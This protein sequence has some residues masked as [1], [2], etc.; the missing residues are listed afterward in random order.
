MP[1]SRQVR[2]TRTAISPRFATNTLVIG[3]GT[4]SYPKRVSERVSEPPGESTRASKRVDGTTRF[5]EVQWFAEID[6][7]NRYLIEQA[8]AGAP[9]GLVAVADLQHSG[10]GRLGRVWTAPSGA[11][12][13]VSVLVRPRLPRDHW[14]WLT[15]A[16]GLAAVET[17]T[18]CC[19]VPARM[20]WPNDVVLE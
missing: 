4:V 18:S 13:L 14:P 16:A 12:L 11:S 2:M 10:K 6:S 9:D 7:T 17:A 19:D 5:R 8:R 1:S 15:A 3:L 20:K